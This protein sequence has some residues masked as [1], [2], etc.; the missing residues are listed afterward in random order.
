MEPIL[1]QTQ[2]DIDLQNIFDK[3]LFELHLATNNLQLAKKI[4]VDN[5]IRK[6]NISFEI[7]YDILRYI[8]NKDYHEIIQFLFDNK[9][10][11]HS[12]EFGTC[13]FLSFM[14]NKP[15]TTNFLLQVVDDV[16]ILFDILTISIS[17]D[18]TEFITHLLT[19]II[20][21][22]E[23]S[24]SY[25]IE[26]CMNNDSHKWYTAFIE[27]L[28]NNSEQTI[29][30]RLVHDIKDIYF[31]CAIENNSNFFFNHMKHFIT[32]FTYQHYIYIS[33]AAKVGN[34]PYLQE[35]IQLLPS[36]QD[37]FFS[38][39]I[40]LNPIQYACI[41]KKYNIIQFL[42]EFKEAR[43]FLKSDEC[44]QKSAMYFDQ[45][46]VL[47]YSIREKFICPHCNH[48]KPYKQLYSRHIENS[49]TKKL[50]NLQ[51]K[52]Y[53]SLLKLYYIVK[54]FRKLP[55]EIIIMFA[56]PTPESRRNIVLYKNREKHIYSECI[57]IIEAL[58]NTNIRKKRKRN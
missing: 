1:Q 15:N 47:E 9:D 3:K 21:S 31:I 19:S 12:I 33:T 32:D 38:N 20:Q 30:N 18:E 44:V 53:T 16:D 11:F 52:Q 40:Q 45:S 50:S 7:S 49:I 24:L 51:T 57:N 48:P 55:N 8:I 29:Y 4:F 56:L 23:F 46:A 42:L 27:H 25:I 28:K 36:V 35:M 39:G 10:T 58:K 37:L 5:T 41:Y 26:T 13:L 54:K 17:R 34:L 43:K 6:R 14:S 2:H 22:D